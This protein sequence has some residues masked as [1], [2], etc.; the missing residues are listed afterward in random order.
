MSTEV[1]NALHMLRIALDR[2]EKTIR[3]RWTKKSR[4]QKKEILQNAWPR[5]SVSHRPDVDKDLLKPRSLLILLNTRGRHHPSAFAHSD[6]ELAPL[7]KL[8]PEIMAIR[9]DLFTMSFMEEKG[10]AS[11]GTFVEWE[12]QSSLQESI[13]IEFT[14]HVDH[15]LQI[16]EI[17][18]GLMLFLAKCMLGI[19]HDLAPKM[20][21][22]E[23]APE[24]PS[25]HENVE[26]YQSLD[27]IAREA[28]YRLP[29]R[30]D[31][32]R[33]CALVSAQK[34]QAIDHAWSL[35]EDPRYFA[36]VVQEYKDHRPHYVLDNKGRPHR[37]AKS[38][39]IGDAH[40]LVFMWEEIGESGM[41]P[42]KS[43]LPDFF[44]SLVRAV[45]Y[46][47]SAT[48]D[49]IGVIRALLPSSPP[50]RAFHF[51]ANPE[52]ANP[53][54]LYIQVKP[55]NPRDKLRDRILSLYDLLV[56][57]GTRDFV[58]LPSLMDE[59]GRLMLYDDRAKSLI[60]PYIA[61]L[62]SQLSPWA[63]AV[64]VA[65]AR[66]QGKLTCERDRHMLVW[67]L[68]RPVDFLDPTLVELGNPQDGKFEFPAHKRQTRQTVEAMRKAESALDAFWK[69]ANAYY[70]RTAGTTPIAE[71]KSILGERVICR[72]PSWV[73]P[74]EAMKASVASSSSKDTY[75]PF[76]S[77]AHEVDKQLTG[78]FKKLSTTTTQKVKTR[79]AAAVAYEP[80]QEPNCAA[81]ID[82]EVIFIVDKRAHKVFRALFHSPNSPDQPGEIAWPDFLHALVST[83]FSAEKLQGS[84]WHFTPKN[85]DVRRSIQFHEPHPGNKLPFMW[86]RRY[87][88]RLTRAYGWTGDMF[89]IA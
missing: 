69:A 28:P 12:D 77:D 67:D 46:I 4:T 49:I 27:A 37:K 34:D 61:S 16:L 26:D 31:F 5:M 72:T 44:D 48:L 17:Q 22:F 89:R 59:F 45:Y 65:V 1:F 29:T 23:L 62:I 66:R 88:R 10:P 71:T 79:G 63:K 78:A 84:A 55:N 7:Y 9:K 47:E 82:K 13:E 15:G 58:T 18:Q 87:G 2:H 38:S 8:R 40:S 81:A 3:N 83:G 50:L 43:V 70:Q 60:S 64:E 51:L 75:Q 11:Y 54:S 33:L 57:K 80:A 68:T 74:A 56:D 24:P 76:L 73:E 35:R 86:G 14:V 25:L 32:S 21:S 52:D 36:D 6:L 39:L 41:K 85:L 30:P 20:L 53:S 42:D 19:L